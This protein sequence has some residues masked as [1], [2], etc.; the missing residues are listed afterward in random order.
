MISESPCPFKS[1][2]TRPAAPRQF[3]LARGSVENVRNAPLSTQKQRAV[4]FPLR[5][6]FLEMH[7]GNGWRCHRSTQEPA[8]PNPRGLAAAQG[9]LGVEVSQADPL[10]LRYR[11][12]TAPK[13]NRTIVDGSG[14]SVPARERLRPYSSTIVDW[15][16]PCPDGAE[17]STPARPIKV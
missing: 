11:S 14:T 4:V 15:P 2:V 7:D 17:Q 8:P 16:P 3:S 6:S 12:V 5:A 13:P 10:T 9:N 1:T